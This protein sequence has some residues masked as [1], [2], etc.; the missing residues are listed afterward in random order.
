MKTPI[1][2]VREALEY[3]GGVLTMHTSI[4]TRRPTPDEY[5]HALKDCDTALT[6]LKSLEGQPSTPRLTVDEAMED[7]LRDAVKEMERCKKFCHQAYTICDHNSI[8]ALRDVP[9]NLAI[10]SAR[11]LL[12]PK[13]TDPK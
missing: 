8:L 3:I 12:T 6:A 5:E 1:E 2:Q 7:A 11:A 13:T 10:T 4:S 9:N